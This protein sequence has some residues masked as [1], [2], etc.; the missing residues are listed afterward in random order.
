LL[1]PIVISN[2]LDL[3]ATIVMPLL[4]LTMVFLLLFHDVLDV[5]LGFGCLLPP[6]IHGDR[7]YVSAAVYWAVRCSSWLF[8]MVH[9]EEAEIGEEE[10]EIE[11]RVW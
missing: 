4:L 10:V 11:R 1:L 5:F 2:M 3:C 9:E 7:G 8:L 6:T